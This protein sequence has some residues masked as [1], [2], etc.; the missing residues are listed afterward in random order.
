M[1]S[2]LA[3]YAASGRSKCGE[4][5][6]QHKKI[7][8]DELRIK[9]CYDD[10]YVSG[11]FYHPACLWK[12]FTY[13]KNANPK[14][15][16]LEDV[17]GVEDL[18]EKDQ[19]TL[20]NLIATNAKPKKRSPEQE[21]EVSRK[22]AKTADFL[23]QLHAEYEATEEENTESVP[24]DTEHHKLVEAYGIYYE[25]K[26]HEL[27]DYLRW[28]RQVLKG[29]KAIN[30]RKVLDGHLNGKFRRRCAY[31]YHSRNT[32]DAWLAAQWYVESLPERHREPHS[33]AQYGCFSNYCLPLLSTGRRKTQ[34]HRRFLCRRVQ[35]LLG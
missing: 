27:T 18:E 29:T 35:W 32:Q 17:H 24:S 21:K 3:E 4:F 23:E 25:M 20:Q 16:S 31:R 5:R 14:I 26:G 2:Y 34:I 7:E 8:K 19:E 10:Q 6:C 22:R 13:K 11:K 15:R 33:T 12:T 9:L 28:N 1:P 30:L